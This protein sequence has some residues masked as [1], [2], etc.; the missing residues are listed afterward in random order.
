MPELKNTEEDKENGLTVLI[1]CVASYK[2]Q[3]LVE[4]LVDLKFDLNYRV[5]KTG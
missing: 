2:C 3:E 1:K 5:K 4:L